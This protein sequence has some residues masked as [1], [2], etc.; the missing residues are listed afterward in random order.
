MKRFILFSQKTIFL[1]VIA[2]SFMHLSVLSQ[3]IHFR[4]S[5]I[6]PAA[7]GSV[8]IGVNKDSS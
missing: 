3:K 6:V 4:E 5:I 7:Q 8:K 2:V 1:S